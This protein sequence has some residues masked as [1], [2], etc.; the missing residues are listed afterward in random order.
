MDQAILPVSG[1]IIADSAHDMWALGLFFYELMHGLATNPLHQLREP[2]SRDEWNAAV[3]QLKAILNPADPIDHIISQLLCPA[4]ERL[5]AQG[6]LEAIEQHLGTERC[7]NSIS[8]QERQLVLER[9]IRPQIAAALAPQEQCPLTP[10]M[11]RSSPFSEETLFLAPKDG[12]ER[13]ERF[14]IAL[15]LAKDYAAKVPFFNVRVTPQFIEILQLPKTG[16]TVGARLVCQAQR[17][18]PLV[19]QQHCPDPNKF[20]FG[21]ILFSMLFGKAKIGVELDLDHLPAP[22]TPEWDR[23]V[24]NVRQYLG[25]HRIDITIDYLLTRPDF[26]IQSSVGVLGWILNPAAI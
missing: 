4:K 25:H 5:S 11:Y 23:I 16:K 7:K 20:S 12:N 22:E 10:E 26:Y 17:A 3:E 9:I 19:D 8:V 6:V 2:F 13:Q 14:V 24:S 15:E 18:E 1:Q 21:L